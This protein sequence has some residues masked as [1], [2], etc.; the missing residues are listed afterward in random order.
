[1]PNRTFV[2]SKSETNEVIHRPDFCRNQ[3]R[4][5]EATYH[6]CLFEHPRREKLSHS[7]RM[8]VRRR[9]ENLPG[10][11]MLGQGDTA[12][13][14]RETLRSAA[15][16]TRPINCVRLVWPYETLSSESSVIWSPSNFRVRVVW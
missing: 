2:E 3:R 16:S 14:S 1:M 6:N 8:A 5:S 7:R 13:R 10:I 11:A 4:P 12:H 9:T 15:Y